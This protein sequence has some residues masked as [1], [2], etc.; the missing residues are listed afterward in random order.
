[1]KSY[2][3]MWFKKSSAGAVS[4][5]KH[6]PWM[7]IVYPLSLSHLIILATDLRRLTQIEWLP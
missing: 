1:V 2:V 6:S 7:T 3:P 5:T 4:I